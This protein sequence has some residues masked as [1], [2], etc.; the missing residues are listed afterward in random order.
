MLRSRLSSLL[1]VASRAL[2]PR[3]QHNAA[4]EAAT[5]AALPPAATITSQLR[6]DP[7]PAAATTQ[8]RGFLTA[9]L[10]A[11]PHAPLAAPQARRA[12]AAAPSGDPQ[13]SPGERLL[14][15]HCDTASVQ[16]LL[17]L[18]Q[19]PRRPGPASPPPSPPHAAPAGAVPQPHTAAAQAQ[20]PPLLEVVLREAPPSSTT[21]VSWAGTGVEHGG[22]GAVG[23]RALP[24]PA[25]WPALSRALQD[26]H[27]A[28]VRALA[29]QGRLALP[30]PGELKCPLPRPVCAAALC[31][32]ML[33]GRCTRLKPDRGVQR[34][35]PSLATA[36]PL[37]FSFFVQLA[38]GSA[39]ELAALAQLLRQHGVRDGA[40]WAALLR[41]ALQPPPPS[42]SPSPPALAP[43]PDASL[44]QQ[45]RR[46]ARGGASPRADPQHS[47]A[48]RSRD[49]ANASAATLRAGRP[50]SSGA[51][52]T[53]TSSSGSTPEHPTGSLPAATLLSL[54]SAAEWAGAPLPAAV[55]TPTL[56][57]L[58]DVAHGVVQEL[59]R[60]AKDPGA[61]PQSWRSLG[62][63]HPWAW[64]AGGP[65]GRAAVEEAEHRFVEVAQRMAQAS[66]APRP[67]RQPRD[68]AAAVAAAV[69]GGEGQRAPPPASV[70][71][72]GGSQRRP[73]GGRLA[74]GGGDSAPPAERPAAAAAAAAA[75]E[76]RRVE[77]PP[78]DVMQR[79]V[80]LVCRPERLL[81][82]RGTRGGRCVGSHCCSA[83]WA[84]ERA[85]Q[86]CLLQVRRTGV[87]PSQ[88]PV[89]SPLLIASPLR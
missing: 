21:S 74:A 30:C 15:Q 31:T 83:L 68:A 56:R 72:P 40:L 8:R 23:G 47:A 41:H 79:G 64:A 84:K 49:G 20:D 59:E 51:A 33:P 46:D 25:F 3:A 76:V 10:L 22:G 1:R 7:G 34:P 58:Q 18:L 71:P 13:L 38:K 55:A 75:R 6:L 48:A 67:R 73:L 66:C 4:P 88:W 36:F 57:Q 19:P 43:A 87:A 37:L 78:G 28:M 42:P 45:H 39:V 54:L 77:A 62:I 16:E 24:S 29:A 2:W 65:E 27:H 63:E 80:R 26:T 44:R 82:V 50:L 9:V 32:A 35:T 14:L 61:P 17:A 11:L 70:D 69:A 5:I 89:C 86:E 12:R 53:T 52:T 81:Q 60:V 85:A